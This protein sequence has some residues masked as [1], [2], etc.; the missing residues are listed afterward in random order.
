MT[1]VQARTPGVPVRAKRAATLGGE[2][3]KVAS[4]GR[5]GRAATPSLLPQPGG[6]SVLEQM[7]RRRGD[8][9]PGRLRDSLG[10]GPREHRQD[11]RA[12]ASAQSLSRPL[13]RHL[14]YFPPFPDPVIVKVEAGGPMG[15]SSQKFYTLLKSESTRAPWGQTPG[16]PS[17]PLA[18]SICLLS[19]A[20][21]L[22]LNGI[23][24][25]VCLRPRQVGGEVCAQ[26]L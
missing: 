2:E 11:R 26:T 5:P 14:L 22:P 15:D 4:L 8:G 17:A 7:A 18:P 6:A 12:G 16:D 19:W 13:Q 24:R 25:P 23:W 3:A 20:P 9:F 1:A 10:C 21:S